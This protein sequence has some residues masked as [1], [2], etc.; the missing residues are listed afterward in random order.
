VRWGERGLADRAYES[1]FQRESTNA[2]IL[3]D[4]AENLRR[5]GRLTQAQTLYRQLTTSDWQPRFASLK[6]QASWML[7]GK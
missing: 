2:Q 4:R 5:A 3:W 1:A 7:D 6:A